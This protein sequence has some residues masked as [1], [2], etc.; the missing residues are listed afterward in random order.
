MLPISNQHGQ[1]NL[2]YFNHPRPLLFRWTHPSGQSQST[3]PQLVP[4]I[5]SQAP[6]VPRIV[7]QSPYRVPL[8]SA[9]VAQHPQNCAQALLNSSQSRVPIGTTQP[10]TSPKTLTIWTTNKSHKCVQAW[11]HH[12]SKYGQSKSN[13]RFFVF[14]S[15]DTKTSSRFCVKLL[16]NCAL[17]GKHAAY[18]LVEFKSHDEE[19]VSLPPL[20][21]LCLPQFRSKY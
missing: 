12:V 18:K 20:T 21:F 2:P 17:S 11:R 13:Q 8:F 4:R 16:M 3:V 6:Y 7:S 19:S 1:L 9:T 14:D 5:V 10:R 15:I